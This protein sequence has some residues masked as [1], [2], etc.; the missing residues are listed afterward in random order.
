MYLIDQDKNWGIP[1]R[2]LGFAFQLYCEMGLA[3]E[4]MFSLDLHN[5]TAEVWYF[6]CFRL[7]LMMFI[8][9]R[10]IVIELMMMILLQNR[11]SNLQ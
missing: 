10:K 8:L 6:Y 1:I 9:R 11:I 7:K 5:H 3:V 2:P 4:I